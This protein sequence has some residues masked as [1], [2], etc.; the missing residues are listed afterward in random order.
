MS[1]PV[2]RPPEARSWIARIFIL[3]EDVVY[4]V[5]GL[6]LAACA[7]TLLVAGCTV[8]VRHAIAGT[9]AE[10]VPA[11]LARIL[12]VLLIVE[13]LYTVQVSFREHKLA[14]EPFIL[15]GLISAIRR[16]LVVTAEFGDLGERSPIMF[17]HFILELA[18]LTFLI[19]ALCLSL[20]L[21]RKLGKPIV[22]ERG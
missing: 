7:V 14:P 9:L 18:V 2:T 12:L 5:L 20:L 11:M 19:V 17:E 13:L 3:F 8:F 15:V 16:V 10:N 22:I 4:V 1:S 21:L 6:L